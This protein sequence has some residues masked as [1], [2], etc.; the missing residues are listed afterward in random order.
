MNRLTLLLSVSA[1]CGCSVFTGPARKHDLETTKNYWFEY[2]ATRR[3]TVLV[4]VPANGSTT[5]R[6]CAEPSPDVANSL[7]SKIESQLQYKDLSVE[8]KGELAVNAVKLADR[9]QMVMF[10]RE[11]LFRVCEISLNVSLSPEVVGRLYDRIIDTALH[12]G[13]DKAFDF[14][15]QKAQ[16]VSQIEL[17]RLEFDI[18][19]A[20]LERTRLQTELAAASAERKARVQA[21]LDSVTKKLDELLDKKK[22]AL[23][24]QLALAAAPAK[25]VEAKPPEQNVPQGSKAGEAPKVPPVESNAP[26]AGSSG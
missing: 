6:S 21:Q 5:F 11:A 20:S 24:K 22:E 12:L 25:Q 7:T 2:D 26:P 4:S 15:A 1:L 8:A 3:G 18:E 16:L 14:D 9:T 23:D 19:R 17:K 13:T 10:F